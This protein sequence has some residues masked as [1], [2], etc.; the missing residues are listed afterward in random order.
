VA[1]SF[2]YNGLIS[3]TLFSLGILFDKKGM[4][5]KWFII[6][7]IITVASF[8]SFLVVPDASVAAHAQTFDPGRHARPDILAT[9]ILEWSVFFSGIAWF[10]S[11]SI[12]LLAK[13]Q[14]QPQENPVEKLPTVSLL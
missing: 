14:T 9:T 5:S 12:Y 4:V 10:V 6:P 7:G 11:T 8:A 1:H 3:T 13:R 2:F